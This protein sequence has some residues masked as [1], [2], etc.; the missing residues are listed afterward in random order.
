MKL[1]RSG[2]KPGEPPALIAYR[3]TVAELITHLTA[4]TALL[5][6]GVRPRPEDATRVFTL[7]I[8]WQAA[9]RRLRRDLPTDPRAEAAMRQTLGTIARF[10]QLWEALGIVPPEAPP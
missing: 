10:Q 2:A 8:A 6:L 4:V 9:V 5:A 3:A 1:R 7:N